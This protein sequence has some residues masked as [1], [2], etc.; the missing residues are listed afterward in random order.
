M[1]QSSASCIKLNANIHLYLH[2]TVGT[3]STLNSVG[4]IAVTNI[5]GRYSRIITT[6]CNY[7]TVYING[8]TVKS[9]STYFPHLVTRPA[10]L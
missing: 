4:I 9:I 2:F 8:I 5:Y 1:A 10:H 3:I 7:T 6:Q